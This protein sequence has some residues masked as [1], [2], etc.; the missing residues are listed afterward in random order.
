MAAPEISTIQPDLV[1]IA[2]PF[3]PLTADQQLELADIEA[4]GLPNMVEATR[5]GMLINAG[6]VPAQRDLHVRPPLPGRYTTRV[7]ERIGQLELLPLV[8]EWLEQISGDGGFVIQ[9]GNRYISTYLSEVGHEVMD[10]KVMSIDKAP[11]HTQLVTLLSPAERHELIDQS[12]AT[13]IEASLAPVTDIKAYGMTREQLLRALANETVQSPFKAVTSD[14]NLESELSAAVDA[15][16]IDDLPIGNVQAIKKVLAGT[17]F[18]TRIQGADE[19]QFLD[20]LF[21]RGRTLFS[22]AAI[23]KAFGGDP[24]AIRLTTLACDKKSINPNSVRPLSLLTPFG[25]RQLPSSHFQ[26]PHSSKL[27]GQ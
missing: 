1:N 14:E 18:A 4:L 12:I 17:E 3:E 24:K 11:L 13:A 25:Y 20:D 26:L 6:V 27:V 22:L 5:M 15:I 8:D 21:Y 2:D 10:L 9:G 7:G 23:V 19:L 16:Q